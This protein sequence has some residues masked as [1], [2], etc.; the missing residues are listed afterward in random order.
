MI[1]VPRSRLYAVA[2]D[3]RVPDVRFHT[4]V[5]ARCRRVPLQHLLGRAWF[6]T[7]ELAVGPGVFV[8]RPETELVAEFAILLAQRLVARGRAPVVVDLGTGSGAIALAVAEEVPS[9]RVLAVEV[10]PAA[11]RW[12]ARNLAAHPAGER[13]QLVAGALGDPLG[14]TLA[15]AVRAS[16]VDALAGADG[17]LPGAVDVVVSNPPYIP[18]GAM[19]R[20]PEVAEH[21][22]ARAL[23][24][25]GTDGLGEV[26]E[27]VATAERLLGAGGA[28]VIEHADVQGG[29]AREILASRG[30]WDEVVG[31]D[32][33]SGRPR[34][35]SA[36]WAGSAR[37]ERP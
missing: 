25:S 1:G 14:W 30:G 10:D 18:P 31:H 5:A 34:F 3:G 37:M 32:D 12:A 20:E 8:P 2:H 13:V 7:I 22:P 19:P 4:L 26:R 28:V 11:R 36:S 21:D 24:G 29:A 17:L 16:P 6:R 27:V 15:G 23:F 35:V 33:F 9:A